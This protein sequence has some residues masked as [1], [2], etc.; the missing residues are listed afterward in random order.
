MDGKKGLEKNIP[1]TMSGNKCTFILI[2]SSRFVFTTLMKYFPPW[3]LLFFAAVLGAIY[4]LT[5][6]YGIV[7][8]DVK[9]LFLVSGCMS[10]MFSII[11][12]LGMQKLCSDSKIGGAVLSMA[13]LGGAV[14]T[15][16]QGVGS[17]RFGSINISLYVHLACFLVFVPYS[18][19]QRI[20]SIK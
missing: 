17:N 1:V 9:A 7:T 13:I 11:Y 20:F 12:G 6:I 18:R 16:M 2:T 8:T 4:A 5:V 10:L 14:L 3:C 15:S 19:V